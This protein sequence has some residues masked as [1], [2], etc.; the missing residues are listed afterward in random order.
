M[1]LHILSWSEAEK[2]VPTEPTFAIR[3]FS[4]WDAERPCLVKSHLYVWIREY[5]FDDNNGI[6]RVWPVDISEE[7]SSRIVADFAVFRDRV[8]ALLV[9]CSRGINRSPAVAVALNE[10]FDLGHDSPLLKRTYSPP[11]KWNITVYNS[12]IEAWR[13]YRK[14]E[15]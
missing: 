4:S 3:I 11:E 13:R 14:Q 12:L 9:H 10:I 2:F 5:V 6:F 15:L 7:I 1:D 8:A